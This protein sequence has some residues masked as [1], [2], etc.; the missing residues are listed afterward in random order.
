MGAEDRTVD[1]A[2]QTTYVT[3]LGDLSYDGYGRLAAVPGRSASYTY[4]AYNRRLKKTVTGAITSF[5][6][7]PTGELLT[8][9][10]GGV[11]RDYVYL[12]GVLT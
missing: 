10:Q 7:L 6:Y 8:E 5:H 12:N 2:G 9:V 1:A 11:P 3:G 4:D